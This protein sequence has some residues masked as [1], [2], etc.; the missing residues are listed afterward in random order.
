[1]CIL[2]SER[3][4]SGSITDKE[5]QKENQIRQE[6]E[7]SPRRSERKSQETEWRLSKGLESIETDEVRSQT[8]TPDVVIR[9][10]DALVQ[11]DLNWKEWF[12]LAIVAAAI[13]FILDYQGYW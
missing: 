4:G 3:T 13:L 9:Y 7:E 2:F 5:N 6:H 8:E 10:R 1:M 11:V 12:A